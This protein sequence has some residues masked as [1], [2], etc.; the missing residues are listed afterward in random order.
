MAS[1]HDESIDWHLTTW[2][3]SRREQL[4]RWQRL[5]VQER[6]QALEEMAEVSRQLAQ[7]SGGHANA[8]TAPSNE[9]KEP[10]VA[11]KDNGTTQQHEVML[12]GCTPMPLASYLKALGVLRLVSEQVDSDARGFWHNDQFVIASKLDAEGIRQ[13][14]LEGY[15]PTPLLA[16]WGARS[17]FYPG[18]AESGARKV[19]QELE[20]TSDS[21]LQSYR[22]SIHAIRALLRAHNFNQK[23]E[24]DH[25]KLDLM[26]LCRAELDEH[27][28]QWLDACYTLTSDWRRFPPLLGTGGNEGSGSY[29]S[30]FGQLVVDCVSKRIHDDALDSALFFLTVPNSQAD[31]VPGQFAPNMAG[32]NNQGTGFSGEVTTNPWD[33]LLALEGTLLFA[34]AST[35]RLGSQE[36][37]N[38]SF[39]FTVQVT[40]AGSGSTDTADEEGARAEMWLPMWQ[41]PAS[42]RELQALLNE[43]RATIGR[44]SVLSGLDFARAVAH[45][46]VDRGLSAFQRYIIVQR[47]GRNVFAVPL[48]R[49]TV[50]R[51]PAA[52]LVNDLDNN[53]W[54]NR[55]RKLARNSDVNRIAALARHLE[56]AIFDLVLAR[57]NTAPKVRRLLTKLGELQLYLAHSKKAQDLTKGGCPPVPWLSQHWAAS[58][59]DGSAEFAIAAALAGLH[60][61]ANSPAN[62]E[63]VWAMP[64]R[65]HLAPERAGRHPW[66]D[67]NTSQNVTWGIGTLEDKLATTLRRRLITANKGDTALNDK[68]LMPSRMASLAAIGAWLEGDLDQ[69]RIAALL[70]GLMLTRVPAGAT[71]STAREAPLPAAY[72]ALKPFFCTNK[73]LVRAGLLSPETR[74]PLPQDMVRRLAAGD[75]EGALGTAVK[76]LRIAGMA[77]DFHN[78]SAGA[79]DGRRLLAALLVP[80]TDYDLKCLLPLS[81]QPAAN[82]QA[83]T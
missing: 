13:Y 43:G 1:K 46:G 28:V 14:F 58:A 40:G 22:D 53:G 15:R 23:P 31:Q 38:A 80:I 67:A 74:L 12:A 62:G 42:Y 21:R 6:F 54:L 52:D 19:L 68:P 27:L 73:Q 44:K 29:L 49:I 35:R 76:R 51:N 30:G 57:E 56:D 78:L 65:E 41:E 60:G 70:P 16:P 75:M 63:T 79:T 71:T 55:F 24:N 26:R 45:L 83:T 4:R 82:E 37:G 25:R 17:G 66:W 72:R 50:R 32:G 48:Q 64:M 3:G 81:T 11:H 8:A 77:V 2:E 69:R 18:S 5:T 20:A 36:Q 47:Y 33:Y 7:P 34:S 59:D 9:V 39:P 10:S 61:V